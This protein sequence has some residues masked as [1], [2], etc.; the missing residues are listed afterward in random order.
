MSETIEGV[1][2]VDAAAVTWNDDAASRTEARRLR[3]R[4]AVGRLAERAQSTDVVRWVLVPG[5]IAVL[6]GFNFMLFGWVGA[7]RTHREIE[8][9][10]YLISGGLVGLALV[11]LGGLLLASALW[12]AVLR[13][14]H[15]EA[16]ERARAHVR[17]S[18]ERMAALIASLAPKQP[19]KPAKQPSANGAGTRTRSR[20]VSAK[21]T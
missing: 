1:H 16:D 8:Q 12:L 15:D 3:F 10:P 17:E 7:S 2:D 20:P 13:R 9:I 21:R 19:A 18:E 4:E 11:F 5:S 6:F 14:M